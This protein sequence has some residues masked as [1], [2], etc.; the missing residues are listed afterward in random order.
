M[1]F[2]ILDKNECPLSVGSTIKKNN[3]IFQIFNISRFGDT[4]MQVHLRAI[5]EEDVQFTSSILRAPTQTRRTREAIVCEYKFNN[6]ELAVAPNPR[7][8]RR[9]QLEKKYVYASQICNIP[10]ILKRPL[11]FGQP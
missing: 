4:G 9:A 6:M 3:K 2:L 5:T 7:S 1:R 11:Q 8:L 10:K